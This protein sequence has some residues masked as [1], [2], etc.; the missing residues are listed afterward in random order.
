M[1]KMLIVGC[2]GAGINIAH[3]FANKKEEG[4]ADVDVFMIDTSDSNIRKHK[5]IDPS[6]FYQFNGLDGS[7]KLRTQNATAV[8]ERS[9]E[10]SNKAAGSDL[11]LVVHSSSGGSGS[12]IGPVLVNELVKKGQN[13]IVL[14]IGSVSSKIEIDNTVKTLK[15]YATISSKNE[16]PIGILYL[17]NNAQNSRGAIDQQAQLFIIMASMFFSG[18]NYE[19]DRSDLTNFLHYNKVTS[20]KPSLTKLDFFDGRNIPLTRDEAVI[21]AVTITDDET[22]SELEHHIEYQAVGFLPEALRKKTSLRMPVHMVHIANSHFSV[23]EDLTKRLGE[24]SEVR[25]AF[26]HREITKD[27]GDESEGI[28]VL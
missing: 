27:D 25:E 24:L 4:Y 5:N 7:G 11:V 22:P 18:M 16:S 9:R 12:V 17:E 14:L 13:V 23:I 28:L 1:N 6:K 15:S 19:L 21:A 10:L 26:I 8:L 2:G 20:Y 3:S